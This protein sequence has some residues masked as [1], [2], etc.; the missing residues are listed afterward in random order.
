MSALKH[1]HCYT[2]PTIIQLGVGGV[3]TFHVRLLLQLFHSL[4]TVYCEVNRNC[5]LWGLCSSLAHFIIQCNDLLRF[6]CFRDHEQQ[7]Y[8]FVSGNILLRA[9]FTQRQFLPPISQ[10]PGKKNPSDSISLTYNCPTVG[11]ANLTLNHLCAHAGPV[12]PY[13]R[14]S[15]LKQSLG[16]QLVTQKQKMKEIK[17]KLSFSA[18]Q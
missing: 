10:L 18:L 16:S 1:N 4:T 5:L 11:V 9:P 7:K 6:W 13:V 3:P 14:G 15:H 17:K 2:S 12:T 8:L